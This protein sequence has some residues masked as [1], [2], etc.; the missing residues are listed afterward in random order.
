MSRAKGFAA[1][2][3]QKR[4]QPLLEDIEGVLREYRDYL[5]LTVRQVFYRLVGKGHPKTENFYEN[6]Q[7]KCNRAR[8]SGR[9][10]FTAIRDDGVSRRVAEKRSIPTSLLGSTTPRTTNSITTTTV[11]GTLTSPLTLLYFARR[12]VWSRCWR[13]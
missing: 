10:S 7:D 3:P 8:R 2:K 5:P 1:W 13:G 4:T 12:R 9:I 11:A 6:V